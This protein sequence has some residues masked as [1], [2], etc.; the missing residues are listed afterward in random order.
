MN[1]PKLPALEP[2]QVIWG[3]FPTHDKGDQWHPAMIL[4]VEKCTTRTVVTAVLGTSRRIDENPDPAAFIV[5]DDED[6]FQF[7]GLERATRFNM[8]WG[9]RFRFIPGT[10]KETVIG[11]ISEQ[12]TPKLYRRLIAA[13]SSATL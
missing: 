3:L 10:R 4:R 5:Y 13:C 2:G 8:G 11:E 9:L 7:T 6:E 12:F 1:I